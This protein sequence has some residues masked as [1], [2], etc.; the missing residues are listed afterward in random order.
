M[1]E[2]HEFECP[3]NLY[4]KL[5][6]D[7]QRLAKEM[8]GDNL[9]TL[10]T[11]TASLQPWIKN[12]PLSSSETMNRMM[13]KIVRHPYFKLCKDISEAKKVFKLEV[14][15]NDSSTMLVEDEKFDVHDFR[16]E[17]VGLFNAFFK[18]K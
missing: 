15:D 5:I 1:T 10:I 14:S 17:I 16:S 2:L 11:T 6:R 3:R 12:S 4:E 9:F 8:N 7:N 13:R 18:A